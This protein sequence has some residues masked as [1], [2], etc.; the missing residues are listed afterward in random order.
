M[1]D[2]VVSWPDQDK[3]LLSQ[4]VV[5]PQRSLWS[6]ARGDWVVLPDPQSSDDWLIVAA[7]RE[8]ARR[9]REIVSAFVGPSV[10]YLSHKETTAGFRVGD[11]SQAALAVNLTTSQPD[12]LLEALQRLVV[13]RASFAGVRPPGRSTLVRLVRDLRLA[14]ADHDVAGS[15]RQLRR[16]REDG[17]LSSENLDFLE[18]ELLGRLGRWRELR[19]LPWFLQITRAPRPAATT[20]LMLESIWWIDFVERAASEPATAL[21]RYQELPADLLRLFDG[22]DVPTTPSARRLAAL[23]SLDQGSPERL[24]RIRARSPEDE[25]RWIAGLF[26]TPDPTVE[27]AP[28]DRARAMLSGGRYVD[29]V[30]LA[31]QFTGDV[32]VLEAAVRAVAEIESPDLAF[33]LGPLLTEDHIGG[34]P[35][36]PGFQRCLD[37]TLSLASDKADS[38][39]EWLERVARN[40]Q[41]PSAAEILRAESPR[42]DLESLRSTREAERAGSYIE[43]AM[44]GKNAV[45]IE[46]GLDLLC[47]LAARL[48]S[49]QGSSRLIDAVLYAL[50]DRPPTEALG[51]A[52]LGLVQAVLRSGPTEQRYA[53]LL[54]VC[55]SSGQLLTARVLIPI[56]LDLLDEFAM[57]PSPDLEKRERLAHAAYE[58]LQSHASRG[59][60]S[61]DEARLA[62]LLLDELGMPD[63]SLW[64]HSTVDSDGEHSGDVVSDPWA[65]L[66][67]RTILLYTLLDGIGARFE[68]RIREF[69]PT[70]R[71]LTRSD[72]VASDQ[73]RSAVQAADYVMVDTRHAKHSATAAIDAVRS[74]GEQ[75]LPEGKGVSSFVR[76]LGQNLRAAG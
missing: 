72:H 62:E 39:T 43:A 2:R 76:C 32:A 56:V 29:V 21:A 69:C 50:I 47:D 52:L 45:A 71:V 16:L 60:L 4:T 28:G 26:Q 44:E 36:T 1:N 54:D 14:L 66:A 25:L 31:L 24:D 70:A 10:G 27:L 40:E 5:Q 64:V 46:Q 42:W 58:A 75:L 33:D 61:R 49:E 68:A 73:L 23:R 18:I 57:Y 7:D 65:Q 51:N 34:L 55:L 13:V 15:E 19:D 8:G 12:N 41:W 17:R 20:E 11:R 37:R 3:T 67:G 74:K 63:R 22:I 6:G 48:A 59:Y 30:A 38:W 35:S 9:A 53:D